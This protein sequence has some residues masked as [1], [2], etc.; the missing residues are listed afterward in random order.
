MG[1]AQGRVCVAMV[2][3]LVSYKKSQIISPA[4]TGEVRDGPVD[5]KIRP[6]GMMKLVRREMDI[7][8]GRMPRQLQLGCSQSWLKA[9]HT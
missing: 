6:L 9:A 2:M 4:F 5:E 8:F 1:V 7:A 3:W